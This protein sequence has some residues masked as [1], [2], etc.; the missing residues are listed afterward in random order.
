MFVHV[1]VRVLWPWDDPSIGPAACHRILCQSVQAYSPL[2]HQHPCLEWTFVSTSFCF[3]TP[4]V[5]V[6][7][8]LTYI[9]LLARVMDKKS[10]NQRDVHSTGPWIVI[11]PAMTT[12]VFHLRTEN[13]KAPFTLPSDFL[14]RFRKQWS[15]FHYSVILN[16][17]TLLQALRLKYTLYISQ[18]GHKLL[19]LNWIIGLT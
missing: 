14:A 12:P 2:L 3:G 9:E 7:M 10:L 11:C 5:P 18:S 4:A 19:D 8:E 13:R 15:T 1:T 16:V 17:A 6:S